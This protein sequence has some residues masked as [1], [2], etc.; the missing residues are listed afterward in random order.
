MG[1]CCLVDLLGK[2]QKQKIQIQ[3]SVRKLLTEAHFARSCRC[4]KCSPNPTQSHSIHLQK[5]LGFFNCLQLQLHLHFGVPLATKPRFTSTTNPHLH[6]S[7]ALMRNREIILQKMKIQFISRSGIPFSQVSPFFSFR[8]YAHVSLTQNFF[9][10]KNTGIVQW[11]I[12]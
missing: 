11:K 10:K 2:N 5:L 7:I 9:S 12:C 3:T 4:A 6:I 8:R 1:F